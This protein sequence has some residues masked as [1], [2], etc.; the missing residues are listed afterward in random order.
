MLHRH[1]PS[2]RHSTRPQSVPAGRVASVRTSAPPAPTRALPLPQRDSCSRGPFSDCVAGAGV[3]TFSIRRSRRPLKNI[4]SSRAHRPGNSQA[5]SGRLGLSMSLFDALPQMPR[6][7]SRPG[8]PTARPAT[9]Q[10]TR[11]RV[12][13]AAGGRA[14]ASDA[15]ALRDTVRQRLRQLRARM[16][17]VK[18]AAEDVKL[19]ASAKQTD[20]RQCCGALMQVLE[21][22]QHVMVEAVASLQESALERL[23][24]QANAVDT[25]AR[26]LLKTEAEL[27]KM[28]SE[29][30]AA[31]RPK[32]S[33][34]VGGQRGEPPPPPPVPRALLSAMRAS[35][36]RQ[37]GDDD[38]VADASFG[39]LTLDTGA[40]LQHL[41]SLDFLERQVMLAP[42]MS[43]TR[44][45]RHSLQIDWVAPPSIPKFPVTGYSLLVTED[46]GSADG[47]PLAELCSGGS[48]GGPHHPLL[49][50]EA[51]GLKSDTPYRF[52]V[53]AVNGQ[54]R[55]LWAHDA[56]LQTSTN[57]EFVYTRDF[58]E[59]GVLFWL[60]TGGAGRRHSYRNPAKAGDVSVIASHPVSSS[61]A[62]WM[63]VG[64]PTCLLTCSLF[65][66][67]SDMLGRWAGRSNA[68]AYIDC[69]HPG[70]WLA[71]DLRAWRLQPTKYTLRAGPVDAAAFRLSNWQL[72]GSCDGLE[73]SVLHHHQHGA[74]SGH[75]Q[76]GT[77]DTVVDPEDPVVQDCGGFFTMFRILSLDTVFLCLSGLELYGTLDRRR[78]V[79][80]G[81]AEAG[82]IIDAGS[83][84]RLALSS[85]EDEDSNEDDEGP[86]L[87][88][89]SEQE[90]RLMRA[91]R[92]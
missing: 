75:F 38:I 31:A 39:N 43:V 19:A 40:L 44:R 26:Q 60:G 77:W 88:P 69:R 42:E 61:T 29:Q 66:L 2:H 59:N 47:V 70:S 54:G 37:T 62:H 74:L 73:W 15:E 72:Q 20:V 58:D 46:D 65:V 5:P 35:V 34:R 64:V 87:I 51:W 7:P 76:S 21:Q 89:M 27:D 55:G 57:R 82:G 16:R 8:R 81:A 14:V 28:L 79:A 36:S 32:S 17:Q 68:R 1:T 63:F 10:R 71:V 78:A 33:T 41:L 84:S 91:L 4:L 92:Y 85:D 67:P 90:K 50:F 80:G 83:L 11:H 13:A 12:P 22:R 45:T 9:A 52:H 48:G 24:R 25:E 86:K 23:Q 6:R 18:V 53:Q 30:E 3:A 56:A 49:R